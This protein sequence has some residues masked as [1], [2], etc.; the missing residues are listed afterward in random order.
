MKPIS[1]ID[2]VRSFQIALR[3][4]QEEK[5]NALRNGV[6]NTAKPMFPEDDIYLMFINW[7]DTF[8]PW[9]LRI[10]NY[11]NDSTHKIITRKMT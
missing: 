5:L 9:H 3:S 8:T 4:H 7:I 11:L 6:I 1:G 2:R 10:L